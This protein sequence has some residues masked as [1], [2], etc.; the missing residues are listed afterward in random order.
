MPGL[1]PGARIERQLHLRARGIPIGA[2][3]IDSWWYPHE[4]L[5]PFEKA[6]KK[7]ATRPK[8]PWDDE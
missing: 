4:A 3:Q 7:P 8:S 2:V 1:L 6:P 5:R